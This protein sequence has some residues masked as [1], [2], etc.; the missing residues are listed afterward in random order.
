MKRSLAIFA[1]LALSSMSLCAAENYTREQMLNL[2]AKYNPAVLERAQQDKGYA[3]LLESVMASYN[4]EQNE[5]NYYELVA[6]VRNFDTSL[7]LSALS[8]EYDRAFPI[9]YAYGL[10]TSAITD[11]F[12]EN[13]HP[14]FGKIWAVTVQVR[15]LQVKDK[16]Q[17]IKDLRH[18]KTLSAQEKEQVKKELNNQ[19]SLLKKEIKSLKKDSSQQIDFVIK[20]YVAQEQEQ[21]LLSFQEEQRIAA[22][23]E[24][25][26]AAKE[27]KNLSVTSKNKKPVAK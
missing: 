10:D 8:Q 12:I 21:S 9:N 20:N 23:M 13:L 11:R 24:Q 3:L 6:L 14:V 2:F 19:L 27:A 16:K 25:E 15:E 7:E 26:K 1:I 18:N 22:A 4:V 5:N 17:Q